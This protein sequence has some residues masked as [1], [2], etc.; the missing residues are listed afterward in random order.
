MK[1][2]L[3][4]ILAFAGIFLF[5]LLPSRIQLEEDALKRNAGIAKLSSGR[6]EI[7][8]SK[9]REYAN[10]R[11]SIIATI[12]DTTATAQTLRAQPL[13]KDRFVVKSTDGTSNAVFFY[14][15]MP[16]PDSTRRKF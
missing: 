6:V 11:Y 15:T 14:I 9:G 1:I 3:G 4:L 7:L 13:A 5:G 10:T 8:L 12:Q 2:I 16:I